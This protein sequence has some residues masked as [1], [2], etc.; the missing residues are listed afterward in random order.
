MVNSVILSLQTFWR[1]VFLLL[2]SVMKQVEAKCRRFVWGGKK[3]KKNI[4]LVKWCNVRCLKPQ[5]GLNIKSCKVW[6]LAAVGKIVWWMQQRR[7]QLWVQWVHNI[8]MKPEEDF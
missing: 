5:G 8:H 7:D 6:T 3:E 4:S 2:H 1:S